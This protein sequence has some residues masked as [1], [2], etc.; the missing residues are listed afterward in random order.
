[1]IEKS[2][3]SSSL[4]ITSSF[5]IVDNVLK[6]AIQEARV[7]KSE[8][9]LEFMR[10]ACEISAFAHITLMKQPNKSERFYSSL[11]AYD[12]PTSAL[13]GEDMVIHPSTWSILLLPA[14]FSQF[15]F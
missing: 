3:L 5:T 2:E 10:K 8:I 14:R 9:E 15:P 7:I 11:F 12:L 6:F 13:L 1:V 4:I